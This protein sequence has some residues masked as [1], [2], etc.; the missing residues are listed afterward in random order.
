[1][2][3]NTKILLVLVLI[4]SAAY[5]LISRKP[6]SNMHSERRDFAV[7][8]TA[9]I[10]KIFLANKNGQ[11]TLLEKDDEGEWNVDMATSADLQK[12]NLIKA[13]LH[14]VEVRN[15]VTEKEFNTVVA[16]LATNAVKVEVYAGEAL[17]KTVYVG[18]A[19][20]E[21]TGTYMMI[22]GSSTPFVTHIPGFVGYLTPRFVPNPAR[23]KNKLVFNFVAPV[24]QSVS[25]SYPQHTT[26]SFQ[27]ENSETPVV[28]NATGDVIQA[29]KNFALYFLSSFTNLYLESYID[30]WTQH[31]QDSLFNTTPFCIL[32]LKT[33][34]NITRTLTVYNKPVDK[35]SKQQL[36][37]KGNPLPFDHEKYIARIDKDNLLAYIQDYNFGRLFKTAQDFST[38]R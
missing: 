29:D 30:E 5:F 20:P 10:T 26:A 31:E 16:N 14:D 24:I 35:H 19:T 33:K 38:L 28:R 6:W 4:A 32:T 23:W 18:E 3:R 12:I 21:G 34:T 17:V 11:H 27:I 15:P 7:T 25:V 8:D 2:T 36:D 13:T 22:E 37:E 9:S 1:M